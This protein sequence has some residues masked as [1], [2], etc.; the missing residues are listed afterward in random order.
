MFWGY[1]CLFWSSLSSFLP[2]SLSSLSLSLSLPVSLSLCVCTIAV[3]LSTKHMLS[4]V[5]ITCQNRVSGMKSKVTRCTASTPFLPTASWHSHH[6]HLSFTPSFLQPSD[7]QWVLPTRE[8]L[9]TVNRKSNKTKT[10][11]NHPHGDN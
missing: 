7:S 8:A 11:R 5:H 2:S 6:M 10:R 3:L 4:Q 1:R 9:H